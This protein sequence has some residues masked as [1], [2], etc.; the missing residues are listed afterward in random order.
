MPQMIHSI[1]FPCKRTSTGFQKKNTSRNLQTWNLLWRYHRKWRRV[2]EH[3][4]HLKH[5]WSREAVSQKHGCPHWA[6]PMRAKLGLLAMQPCLLTLLL[7]GSKSKLYFINFGRFYFRLKTCIFWC[8]HLWPKRFTSSLPAL[9]FFFLNNYT[10]S[11]P[12]YKTSQE[13]WRVKAISSLTKIIEIN[14]ES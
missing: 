2:Q 7:Q 9:P 8:F 12:N 5:G 10:P 14:M 3:A 1:P 4:N 13:S 6:P 11:I